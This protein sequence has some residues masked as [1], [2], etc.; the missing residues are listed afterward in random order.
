MLFSGD[1][2]DVPSLK[3]GIDDDPF[4]GNP[5]I[6][7]GRGGVFVSISRIFHININCTNL[8]RSLAFYQ[9]LGF[10]AWSP[11][12]SIAEAMGEVSSKNLSESMK[13][14]GANAKG[15]LLQLGDDASACFLDLLEWVQPASQ[16]RAYERLNHPGITRVCLHSD[17]IWKDYEELKSK[18]IVFY[19]EPKFLG[20]SGV[21][22]QIVF[23]EDPD[24]TVLELAQ[25]S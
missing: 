14:P 8:E 19:S 9:M 11:A 5:Q 22:P 13:L 15:L 16:G 23:F 10:K 17:D 21:G 3:R 18:G 24:G 12:E 2:A 4:S 6:T 7:R 20:D 1:L 25:L